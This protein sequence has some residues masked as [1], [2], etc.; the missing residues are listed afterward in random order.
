MREEEG[1]D[2]LCLLVGS[3]GLVVVIT[4]VSMGNPAGALAQAPRRPRRASREPRIDC[5]RLQMPSIDDAGETNGE[6]RLTICS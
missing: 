3:V 1:G 4:V 2:F 5:C 6:G